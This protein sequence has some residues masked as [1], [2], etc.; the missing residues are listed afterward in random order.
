MSMRHGSTCGVVLAAMCLAS[1]AG[2]RSAVPDTL[3]TRL[4]HFMSRAAKGELQGVRFMI[5]P[6]SVPWRTCSI[7][8]GGTDAL[9]LCDWLVKHGNPEDMAANIS[10]VTSCLDPRQWHPV[11]IPDALPEYLSSFTKAVRGGAAM[12]VHLLYDTSPSAGA[13]PYDAFPWLSVTA[14]RVDEKQ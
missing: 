11:S 14:H 5:N 9:S 8:K 12:Y 13:N 2:T 10:N 3:C 1:C 4:E 6:A 7:L